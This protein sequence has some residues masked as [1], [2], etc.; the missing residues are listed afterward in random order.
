MKRNFL[1]F[2]L[3]VVTMIACQQKAEVKT[4]DFETERATVDSFINQ[5]NASFSTKDVAFLTSSLTEDAVYLGTDPSENMSKQQITELWTEMFAQTDTFPSLHF[6][7]DRLIKLAP[8]GNSATVVDQHMMPM[9][10]P[11]IP[12]RNVYHLTK[13]D[14]AWKIY[15]GSSAFIPKNEDIPKLNAAMEQDSF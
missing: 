7:S 8:D 2:C 12:W 1:F 5:F 6:I 11:K 15:F 13:I 4:P 3:M 14:G 9:Y 10:T